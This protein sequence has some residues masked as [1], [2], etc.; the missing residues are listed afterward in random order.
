MKSRLP[1]VVM[2]VLMAGGCARETPA[3]QAALS[4]GASLYETH[5]A[6]CHGA[7][8]DGFGQVPSHVDFT[9]RHW[10]QYRS[11]A[12]IRSAI[13]SGVA[14]TTMPAFPTLSDEQL[15]ALVAHLRK[16]R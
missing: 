9:S 5:C 6:V 1:W 14:G 4:E 7:T 2:T 11:E 12:D 16:F 13:R 10:Q 3:T 15:D 8:G